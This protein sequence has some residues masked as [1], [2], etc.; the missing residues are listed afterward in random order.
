MLTVNLW[1]TTLFVFN[2]ISTP[3]DNIDRSVDKRIERIISADRSR[4]EAECALKIAWRESRYQLHVRNSTTGAYG[5]FQ[6]MQVDKQMNLK[7]QI[8]R[9]TKYVEHRYGSPDRRNSWCKAWS[10]WQTKGWY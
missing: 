2:P 6:L 9:A 7:K 4:S 5:L 3:V 1:I 10:S 8:D